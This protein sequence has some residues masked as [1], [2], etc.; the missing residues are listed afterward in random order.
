VPLVGWILALLFLAL[1]V[2]LFLPIAIFLLEV[3][4]FVGLATLVAGV[5]MIFRRP[6][7]VAAETQGPP[8]EQRRWRVVGWRASGR[9]VE[10]ITEQIQLGY[11]AV[12]P[13]TRSRRESADPADDLVELLGDL[14]GLLPAP[15]SQPRRVLY[16]A[17]RGLS[18]TGLSE[19]PRRI[20]HMFE[21]GT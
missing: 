13:G 15:H 2:F 1:L 5:R 11:R 7:T 9:A 12:H 6:W 18:S 21:A 4:L 17:A 8:P 14:P 20:E 10:D 16:G 3:V 19:P